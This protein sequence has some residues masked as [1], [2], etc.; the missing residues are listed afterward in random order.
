MASI[1]HQAIYG[2][3]ALNHSTRRKAG[4]FLFLL[5]TPK[6]AAGDKCFVNVRLTLVKIAILRWLCLPLQ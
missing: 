4:F 2:F 6:R 5:V 1:S 3:V